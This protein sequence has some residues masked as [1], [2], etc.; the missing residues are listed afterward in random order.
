MKG[1]GIDQNIP[2]ADTA[3]NKPLISSDVSNEPGQ[4]PAATEE[5]AT[6][7]RIREKQTIIQKYYKTQ[8]QRT[9]A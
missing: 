1:M 9:T 7:R 4:K 6:P 3:N 8:K 5:F 2:V